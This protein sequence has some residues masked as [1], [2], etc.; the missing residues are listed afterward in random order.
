MSHSVFAIYKAPEDPAAFDKAYENHAALAKK[1]P[2]LKELRVN[3]TLQQVTG[4]TPLYV[5]TELVFDSLEDLQAGLGSPEGQAT[6]GDLPTWGGDKLITTL[7]T[8][9]QDA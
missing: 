6:S 2:G 4:E 7:V 1:I 9:R 5:V 3:K 8:A